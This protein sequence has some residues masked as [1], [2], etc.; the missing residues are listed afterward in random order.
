MDLLQFIPVLAAIAIVA[1]LVRNRIK[2]REMTQ[3][4]QALAPV[5][6]LAFE[7]VTAFGVDLTN[8][9]SEISGH[10]LDEGATADYQRALDAYE[11]AKI[12]GDAL[13]G[14]GDIRHLTEIIE[15]GRYAVACVRAR[16]SGEPLPRRRP[17]CFFDPRHGLSVADVPYTPADG[18]ERQVPACALDSQR[19]RA[20]AEPD[21]RKVLVGASRVPYWEGGRAYAPYAAGYFGVDALTW[22]FIG[23]LAFNDFGEGGSGDDAPAETSG[24][25]SHSDDSSHFDG[26]GGDF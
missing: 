14:P 6:M 8:L 1:F 5:R 3:R 19:V 23:S 2:H 26:G 22:L 9:D 4:E 7:D 17:P 20:G 25:G 11:S 21:T 15:D 16:V 13:T 12:A 18:M 10:V 24:A